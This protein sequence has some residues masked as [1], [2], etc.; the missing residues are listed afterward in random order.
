MVFIK[1][2]HNCYTALNISSCFLVGLHCLHR[3]YWCSTRVSLTLSPLTWRIWWAPNNA[4]RW[5]MGFNLAFKGLIH[6]FNA[7]I[8]F[9]SWQ[10]PVSSST[11]SLP[12][13]RG[14]LLFLFLL[15]V[16]L[17]LQTSPVLDQ[18]G[19]GVLSGSHTQLDTSLCERW[20]VTSPVLFSQTPH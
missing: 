1:I 20:C 15:L 5:Q 17:L 12:V 6:C 3:Y 8:N 14:I 16:F 10:R 19:S 18:S 2:L 9:Y 13:P 11:T 4:I 7:F